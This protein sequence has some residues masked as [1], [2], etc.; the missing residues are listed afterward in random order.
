MTTPRSRIGYFIVIAAA[1]VGLAGCGTHSGHPAGVP[2][3]TPAD[4]SPP[5]AVMQ[6]GDPTSAAADPLAALHAAQLSATAMITRTLATMFTWYPAT[7]GS[8]QTALDRASA[9]LTPRMIGDPR[10][11]V[12]PSLQWSDWKAARATVVATAR[13]QSDE[14][15]VPDSTTQIKRVVSVVQSVDTG[16]GA[17]QPLAPMTAYV[18]AVNVAGVWKI[19]SIVYS[20]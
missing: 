18:T 15:D 1:A 12:A 3:S 11:T 4:T 13:V 10:H 14:S 17:P 6:P 20:Y 9:N 2:S 7:D 5:A 16:T 8:P 19:D